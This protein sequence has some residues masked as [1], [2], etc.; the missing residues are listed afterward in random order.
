L[1]EVTT[2]TRKRI[3][4]DATDISVA[5]IIGVPRKMSIAKNSFESEILSDDDTLEIVGFVGGG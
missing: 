3:S 1:Y 2:S 4:S 5:A